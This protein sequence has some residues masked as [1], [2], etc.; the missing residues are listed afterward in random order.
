V[1]GQDLEQLADVGRSA[2]RLGEWELRVDRVSVA[3]AFALAG[4]VAGGAELADD[5]VCGA[6][7]DPD[8]AADVA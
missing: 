1:V 5:P 3:S 2:D 8:A 7:G 4:D 6:F